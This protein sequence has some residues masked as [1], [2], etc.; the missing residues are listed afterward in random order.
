MKL[1]FYEPLAFLLLALTHPC[2][3]VSLQSLK[4]FIQDDES[5]GTY[6]VV[7]EAKPQAGSVLEAETKFEDNIK[8]YAKDAAIKLD[9]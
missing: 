4:D 6:V 5:Q 9:P 8:K 7:P 3:A 2:Q 1:L